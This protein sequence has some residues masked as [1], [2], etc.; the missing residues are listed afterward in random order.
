MWP[1]KLRAE[2][3]AHRPG[4]VFCPVEWPDLVATTLRRQGAPVSGASLNRVESQEFP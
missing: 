2:G 4:G 1:A 3:R